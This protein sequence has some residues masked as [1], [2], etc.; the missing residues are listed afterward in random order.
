MKRLE[1][2]WE[3]KKDKAN[4]KKHGVS[5]DEARTVFYDESALQFFD[6]DHSENEDRFLLLGTSFK[7]KALVV[8]HCYREEET[9]IRIISARKA[10]QDEEQFYWRKRK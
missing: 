7:L 8:C 5:F 9:I 3:K 10:D 4:L 1:F 2:E 6:P